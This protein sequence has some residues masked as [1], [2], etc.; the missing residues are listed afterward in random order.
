MTRSNFARCIAVAVGLSSALWGTSFHSTQAAKLE[1]TQTE[2]AGDPR[3]DMVTILQSM[4][5]ASSLGDQ[6]KVFGRFV[7]TWDA[8]FSFH[9]K[10][11]SVSHSSGEVVFGWVMDGHALQDLWIGYPKSPGGQRKM[12][13]T[14][15]FF[16]PKS[17]KWKVVFVDPFYNAVISVEGGEEGDRIVLR[18]KDTDGSAIR[19]SFLD[20]KDDSFTWHGETSHDGGKSW[21][22]EEEHHFK[23]RA[24]TSAKS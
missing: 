12:G 3:R 21:R 1:Q 15:R 17:G 6:A 10:D 13:T 22:L 5:P 4:G 2:T 16:D 18:G 19:W 23:R 9:S 11:G 8:D 14:V 7:G 24:T 20:I